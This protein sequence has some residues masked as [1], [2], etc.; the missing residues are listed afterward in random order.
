MPR[1]F[2]WFYWQFGLNLDSVVA[3]NVFLVVAIGDFNAEVKTLYS[4]DKTTYEG[5][6]IESITSQFGLLQLIKELT[7][8]LNETSSYIDF[9]FLT[10]A[11][12][13]TEL[14]FPSFLHSMSHPQV[15][16]PNFIWKFAMLHH[17]NTNFDIMKKQMVIISERQ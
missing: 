16:F 12:L 8:I 3:N 4:Q 9:L 15:V 6:R 11:N 5:S 10:E 17:K 7:H 2:W 14:G 13:M 1:C